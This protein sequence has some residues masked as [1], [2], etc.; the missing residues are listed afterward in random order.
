MNEETGVMLESPSIAHSLSTWDGAQIISSSLVILLSPPEDPAGPTISDHFHAM[1]IDNGPSFTVALSQFSELAKRHASAVFAC[2]DVGQWYD[3]LS[4]MPGNLGAE[5]ILAFSQLIENSRLIDLT[6]LDRVLRSAEGDVSLRPR[7][8][9][10]LMKTAAQNS[11]GPA[12]EPAM[13]DLHQE[14]RAHRQ[15]CRYLLSRVQS[16]SQE[17]ELPVDIPLIELLRTRPQAN[18]KSDLGVIQ[19]RMHARLSPQ[20]SSAATTAP[21]NAIAP[22][23]LLLQQATRAA[24]MVNVEVKAAIVAASMKVSPSPKSCPLNWLN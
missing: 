3:R 6:L 12:G 20:P 14:S 19:L 17:A 8:F 24:R 16:L 1:G 11:G 4:K 23:S 2:A 18:P 13:D 15:V 9:A 7:S 10:D 21:Q 5:P 22:D